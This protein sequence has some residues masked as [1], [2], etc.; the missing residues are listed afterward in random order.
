M[1]DTK[2]LLD[3]DIYP[4][5]DKA[6]AVRDLNP[7]DRGKYYLLTC[8]QCGKRETYRRGAYFKGV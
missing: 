2:E 8:P 6:E 5:L 7:Q 4:N 3:F 1:K